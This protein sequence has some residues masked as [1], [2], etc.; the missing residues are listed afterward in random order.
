M[1]K[2][3]EFVQLKQY[4]DI[5]STFSVPVQWS[6]GVFLWELFSRGLQPYPGVAHSAVMHVVAAGKRMGKPK[7]APDE[8]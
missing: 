5:I 3:D 4:F 2:S 1:D 7:D 8:M 6:Y